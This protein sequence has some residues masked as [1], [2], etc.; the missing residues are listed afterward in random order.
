MTLSFFRFSAFFRVG[1]LPRALE[2]FLNDLLMLKFDE[3]SESDVIFEVTVNPAHINCL[4]LVL[5]D[6]DQI[7][8]QM[9]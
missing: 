1:L 4:D 9:L 7:D 6:I 3:E 2:N 8:L 5:T